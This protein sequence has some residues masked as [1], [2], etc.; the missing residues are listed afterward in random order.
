MPWLLRL[1]PFLVLP[2]TL[3]AQTPCPSPWVLREEFKFGSVDG[4]QAL[5]HV[6]DFEIGRDG[7]LYVV[8]FPAISVFDANGRPSGTIGRVG[9]GPGEFAVSAS[10]IGFRGD[11]LWATDLSALHFLTTDGKEAYQLKWR[12]LMPKEGSAFLPA[13]PMADGTVLGERTLVG[14]PGTAPGIGF[15]DAERL[16]LLRF[17]RTGT[18]VDTIAM[19]GWNRPRYV[20]FAGG[21]SLDHPLQGMGNPLTPGIESLLPVVVTR[22]Y[23]AVILIGSIKTQEAAPTLRNLG[24][25]LATP[26]MTFQL[27]R[28]A[29]DGDTLLNTAIEYEP[30]P[31][32]ASMRDWL[33][34]NFAAQRAGDF[35]GRRDPRNPIPPPSSAVREQ[36]RAEA[37]EAITF[38][39]FL[40]PV[41][42]ILAGE[43][44]TIWLLRELREDREDHWEVYTERGQLQGTVVISA[45]RSAAFP[46]SPR[47]RLLR[48]TRDEVWGTT[49][50]D[51][52][53]PTIHRYRI[54]K[55]C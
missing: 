4:P 20:A 21:G 25:L 6:G 30:Q 41:R 5:S 33:R 1:V 18:V 13:T 46:W 42:H 55:A 24:G 45:G 28:I 50:D 2:H 23:R 34:E 32:S 38:P 19:V 16:P 7:S 22:D 8:Q 26:A 40:P 43:D 36:R 15:F 48:A 39:E 53:V 47:V 49:L 54:D 27:L 10:R 37:R 17:D 51:L 29:I 35:S 44:G 3:S 31:V 12:T 52:D 11:T 14:G 9:G